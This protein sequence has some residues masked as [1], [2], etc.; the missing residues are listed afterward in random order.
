MEEKLIET[1]KEL[2]MEYLVNRINQIV[3]LDFSVVDKNDDIEKW[4]TVPKLLLLEDKKI[5]KVLDFTKYLDT[6]LISIYDKAMYIISL[7]GMVDF[8]PFKFEDYDNG[9]LLL[10]VDYYQTR[11]IKEM[12]D[13]FNFTSNQALLTAIR[14]KTLDLEI[15]K[16]ILLSFV[17][18]AFYDKID[19][20]NKKVLLNYIVKFIDEIVNKDY[21]ELID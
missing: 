12:V 21:T 7:S 9:N 3:S 5:A 16:K 8:M 6:L 11:G 17:N 18:R 14:N 15:R 13:T 1:N 4:N 19:G 2:T 20:T 10:L